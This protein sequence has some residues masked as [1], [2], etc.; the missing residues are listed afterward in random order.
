MQDKSH[1]TAVA[2]V[3]PEEVWGPIQAIREKHD[4]QFRRW[5]PHVNL[6]FP[7]LPA[8]WFK[9]VLPRLAEVCA[10]NAPLL[11]TLAEFR[12]FAHPSGRETL[13]LAPQP[14]D[15]LARLQAAH[16]AACL[17][18]DDLS[19]F[20]AGFT[21]H[22]SVG[23]ARSIREARKHLD[24]W[25]AAWTPICFRL[26]SVAVLKCGQDTPYEF[27]RSVLPAGACPSR[28]VTTLWDRG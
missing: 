21:P 15:D 11:V 26:G 5:M 8:E 1:Q 28:S 22:L 7:F 20:A 16:Q 9:D 23:Q 25:Q 2:V 6:L 17:D 12:H 18:C 13:W 10:G 14:K 27:V 19:R 4:R 24:A 3:P